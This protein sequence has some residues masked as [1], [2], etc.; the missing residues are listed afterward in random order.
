MTGLAGRRAPGFRCRPNATGANSI[1]KPW[2]GLASTI[3][4]LEMEA[5]RHASFQSILRP[6]VAVFRRQATGE[7]KPRSIGPRW[8]SAANPSGEVS[9]CSPRPGAT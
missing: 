9:T 3:R 2:I 6:P 5:Q 7:F 8:R 4:Y 1:Q